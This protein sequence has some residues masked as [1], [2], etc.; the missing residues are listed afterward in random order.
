M[1]DVVVHCIV[2]TYIRRIYRYD[3]IVKGAHRNDIFSQHVHYLRT[4]FYDVSYFIAQKVSC[5]IYIFRCIR[6]SVGPGIEY[7]HATTALL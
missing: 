6:D 5:T 1:R 7:R 4:S 2:S 3:G